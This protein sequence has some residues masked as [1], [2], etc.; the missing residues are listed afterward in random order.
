MA[1][2]GSRPCKRSPAWNREQGRQHVKAQAESGLTVQDYCFAHGLLVHTFHNWRRRLK[3]DREGSS[4]GSL[5]SSVSGGP[6]FV[7]VLVGSL[8]PGQEPA[9]VEVI[10][11]GGRRLRVGRGF[12]EE[13]L[14]RLVTLLESLPC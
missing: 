10:L 3:R 13:T 8:E 14:R 2:T 4:S 7:E 12:D 6:A 1:D 9:V 5:E 11:Q